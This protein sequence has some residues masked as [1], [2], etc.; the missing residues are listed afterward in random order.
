MNEEILSKK[1]L[2]ITRAR[3][4][5]ISILEE[6]DQPISAENLYKIFKEKEKGNLSTIYRNLK[7]L[8]DKDVVEIAC[9]VDGISYYRL[10]QKKH[11][12]SIICKKCGKI[13]PIENC[14]MGQIQ[15]KL[16]DTTGFKIESHILEFRGI[17]PECQ[18]KEE[19]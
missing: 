9:E 4:S 16:E 2:K 1:G 18:K 8:T 17:C 13:I 5:I 11:K 7:T 14:P 19:K 3:K 10:K 15:S 12:H 6:L